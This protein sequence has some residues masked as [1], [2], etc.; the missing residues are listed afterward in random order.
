MKPKSAIADAPKRSRSG[1]SGRTKSRAERQ[2]MGHVR[3][4]IWLEPPDP[5]L[6]AD[7]EAADPGDGARTRVVRRAIRELHARTAGKKK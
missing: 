1:P 6:L 4:E 3:V 5:D 2:A 7:L